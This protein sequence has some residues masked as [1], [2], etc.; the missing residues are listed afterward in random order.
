MAYNLF[1]PTSDT[2]ARVNEELFKSKPPRS[3][4]QPYFEGYKEFEEKPNSPSLSEEG[5]C[6]SYQE[7]TGLS[8]GRILPPQQQAKPSSKVNN[9]VQA[10]CEVTLS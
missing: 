4:L 10:I 6:F 1:D 7:L 3:I 9:K 2:L 8:S 5:Q